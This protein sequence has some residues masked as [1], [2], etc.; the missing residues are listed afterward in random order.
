MIYLNYDSI[1]ISQMAEDWYLML[2]EFLTKE[3]EYYVSYT[4]QES[5]E[6]ARERCCTYK[7]K[8]LGKV[9][10][11]GLGAEEK[12]LCEG[13]LNL[14]FSQLKEYVLADEE[15]LLAKHLEYDAAFI[16]NDKLEAKNA[17]ALLV[18][19][20]E[21]LYDDFT[22]EYAYYFFQKLNIRTCP[23]CNRNYTFT[24]KEEDKKTRPEY[25]HFFNKSSNPLL[26]VSFYNLVPSCH[27]CNHI[28]GTDSLIINPY[29]HGF[30]GVFKISAD[31]EFLGYETESEDEKHDMRKLA[32][33]GLYR[34]HDDYVQEIFA[35]AQAYNRQARE[36]LVESF[37]G[38]G[39]SP[40]EVYDFVWGKNLEDAR[41]INRPLSKLTR[42]ILKQVGV[43]LPELENSDENDE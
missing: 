21:D 36:A 31:G 1:R 14:F 23:Y 19:I 6:N 24:V 42:D 15:R 43:S 8:M 38:A 9:K 12:S 4:D 29:F 17:H 5:D 28:K 3:G 18:K 11:S 34:E 30:T 35:K 16:K 41:Q 22:K 25:D 27:T 7:A 33:N 39:E 20:Y 10:W 32:L 26:A 37:Q 2:H 13:Q 40:S